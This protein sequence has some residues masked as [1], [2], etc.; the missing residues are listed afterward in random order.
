M[1]CVLCMLFVIQGCSALSVIAV[2]IVAVCCHV[3]V[4]AVKQ[5]HTT[6]CLSLVLLVFLSI[7]GPAGKP[8][9]PVDRA[10]CGRPTRAQAKVL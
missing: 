5:Q 2:I 4:V 10:P 7:T 9:P 8:A 1:R 3:F 6:T